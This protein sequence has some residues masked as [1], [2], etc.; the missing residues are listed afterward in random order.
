VQLG[1]NL[2]GSAANTLTIASNATF[3]NYQVANPLTWSLVLSNSSTYWS[4][5]G[6]GL[7]NDWAGPVSLLGAATLQA[8]GVITISGEV[9][10]PGSFTK[11]G[12]STATLSASN[13]YTG[14][15]TI[16]NGVLVVANHAAVGTGLVTINRSAT[17]LVVNDDVTLTNS[18][19]INGGGVAYRGLIENSGAGNATLRGGTITINGNLSGGGHFG[20]AAGGT[21]TIADPINS[22]TN[23]SCRIGT[24][25][26]QG[27]GSYPT[28]IQNEGTVRLGANNGLATSA[29]VELAVSGAGVL[30]LAG[31]NQ[32]L[33]GLKRTTANA[34]IVTNSSGT[35]DSVLTIT[36]ASIFQG[37]IEDSGVAGNRIALVVN[38]G[39]LTLSGSN[40]YSGGTLVSAGK[41]HVNNTAG[42]GTGSGAVTVQS[43]ATIGGQGVLAG[44]ATVSAGATLAP[45]SSTGVGTLTFN[46]SLSFAGNVSVDLDKSLVQS[47][48]LVNVLGTLNH[49][50]TGTLTVNNLGPA[51]VAGDTFKLFSQPVPNGNALTV[52]GP[53][54]VTFTNHLATD[55]GITVLTAA[56]PTLNYAHTGSALEF[57]WTGNFKLQA[58]TNA[59]SVGLSTNWVDYPGGGSSPV[60]VPLDATQGSVFFRLMSP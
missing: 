27:G 42:S 4:Q 14:G 3:N 38:G 46:G 31:F 32:T 44:D 28:F 20:S 58:Q 8:D 60:S 54:G 7:Q 19:V 48:D 55:G 40:T 36:G 9:T 53:A 26:F 57:S 39:D 30:D 59:L 21:L 13:S 25:I 51:L 47:N 5:S 24:V 52:V 50:G 10:G 22:T 2:G 45:G 17:R 23:V 18:I 6:S 12:A 35:D 33:A 29:T 37:Q 43:G 56:P 34:A 11:I 49:T 15:T 1:I 16:T 41:L